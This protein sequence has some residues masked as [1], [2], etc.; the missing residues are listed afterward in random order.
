MVGSMWDILESGCK[1]LE[2]VCNIG[3]VFLRWFFFV[4]LKL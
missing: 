4:L 2:N 3:V 1:C